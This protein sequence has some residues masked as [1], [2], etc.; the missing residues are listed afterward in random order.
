M[1][2]RTVAACVLTGAL[3]SSCARPP[4]T[5]PTIEAPPIRSVVRASDGPLMAHLYHQNGRPLKPSQ[6]PPLVRDAVIAAEDARFFRHDGVDLRAVARA[7]GVDLAAGAPRQGGS[8]ITQQL[9]KLIRG[10]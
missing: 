6:L 5:P 2:S 1:R 4:E 10:S 7:A 9:A 3:L 8:T